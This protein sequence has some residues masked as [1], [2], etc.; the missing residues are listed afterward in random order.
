MQVPGSVQFPS[1]SQEIVA[2]L[3]K[4]GLKFT[5]PKCR[6][7]KCQKTNTYCRLYLT[8]SRQPPSGVRC[9]K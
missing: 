7:T 5:C 8:P 3:W 1:E 2:V 6:K 4:H 9:P